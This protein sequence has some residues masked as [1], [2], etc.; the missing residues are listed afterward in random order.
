MSATN[1]GSERRRDDA[2]FTPPPAVEVLLD[3]VQPFL[4]PW[5][6]GGR[7]PILEPAA[8]DGAIIR[9][10]HARWPELRFHAVE[11]HSEREAELRAA[12]AERIWCRDFLSWS[13]ARRWHL[14]LGNPPYGLAQAFVDKA[15]SLVEPEGSVVFLLRL[16]FLESISRR[17]WHLMRPL[18]DVWVLSR[19]PSFTGGGTDATAYAWMHWQDGFRGEANLSVL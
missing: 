12:G 8:G 18:R 13:P 15:L 6:D 2:Y 4:P 1:R 5:S 3:R 10:V 17:D 7:L 16:P 9:H 19:R 11:L 14:V